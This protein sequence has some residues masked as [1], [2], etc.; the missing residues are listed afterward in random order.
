MN[1]MKMIFLS[2]CFA[3][4]CLQTQ[5]FSS[6]HENQEPNTCP[7]HYGHDQLP[8]HFQGF[9]D[10]FSSEIVGKIAESDPAIDHALHYEDHLL[11]KN[12][13]SKLVYYLYI[14]DFLDSMIAIPT[15]NVSVNSSTLDSSYLAGRAPIYKQGGQ[16]FGVCSASFLCMQNQDGIFSDIANYLVVDNGLI[17]SWLTPSTLANLE[18]DSIIHGMVTECIVTASTKVGFNPFYGKKFNM[19]VSADNDRIY[20]ELKRIK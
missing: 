1:K 13:K 5:G 14:Q 4:L 16:K 20:F 15:S 19:V 3:F 8:G 2:L 11:A 9:S 17:V 18:L 6:V 10:N 7:L 12:K